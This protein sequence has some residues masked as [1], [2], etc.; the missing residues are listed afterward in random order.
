MDKPTVVKNLAAVSRR[1][2]VKN[3]A[4]G[5]A[6]SVL[7]GQA[8]RASV[9]AD[10]TPSGAGRLRIKLS[11]FPSLEE[12]NTS[13]RLGINPIENPI[14]PIGNFYPIL[15]NHHTGNTYYALDTRCPHQGC[16]VPPYDNFEGKSLCACHGSAFGIS[17]NLISNGPSPSPLRQFPIT[18]DGLNTLTVDVP[19]LGYTVESTLVQ[20]GNTPRLH[21][22]FHAFDNVEYEVVFRE[23]M[24]DAWT[25]IPFSLTLGGT[26][27][28]LSFS[29]TNLEFPFDGSPVSLF[30]NRTTQTGFYSV[31][32]KLLDLTNG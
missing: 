26:A 22:H 16:I 14:D 30:V 18:F 31:G 20:S 24:Q 1:R 13:I 28:Q 21:L 12:D 19:N 32:I 8:W 15:I 2:F 3:F 4:L 6:S 7:F 10:I 11:D 23:R 17:G 9:L 29:R 27:S 5:T 25:V